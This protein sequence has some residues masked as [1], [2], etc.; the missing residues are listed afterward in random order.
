[1]HLQRQ[2]KPDG[3]KNVI[4]VARTDFMVGA[5]RGFN[6]STFDPSCGLVIKFVEERGLD[7]GG[8]TREFMTLLLRSIKDSVIFVGEKKFLQANV[9]G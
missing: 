4:N 5:Q 1:M 9:S 8:P 6:K 3:R 2:V 7:A